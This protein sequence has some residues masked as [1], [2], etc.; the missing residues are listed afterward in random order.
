MDGIEKKDFKSRWENYWYYYKFHTLLAIFAVFVAVL[1]IISFIRSDEPVYLTVVDTTIA[2]GAKDSAELLNGFAEYKGIDEN[3]VVLN[4][5]SDYVTDEIARRTGAKSLPMSVEYGDI[6][7]VFSFRGYEFSRD[8]VGNIEEIL[9]AELLDRLGDD[10]IACYLEENENGDLV[11]TEDTASII[12]NNAARFKEFYGEVDG[13]VVLQIPANCRNR[14]YAVEF[15]R[16]LF[17]ISD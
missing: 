17:D 5:V 8:Y 16:Y 7:I 3:S 10:V 13:V 12:V 9:P 15:V 11:E 1:I 14:E 4:N 2:L 6:E